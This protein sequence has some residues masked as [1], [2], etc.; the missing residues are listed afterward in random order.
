MT[1]TCAVKGYR[2]EVKAG[3]SAYQLMGGDLRGTDISGR[4]EIAG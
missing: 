1:Y 2:G 4:E 3:Q